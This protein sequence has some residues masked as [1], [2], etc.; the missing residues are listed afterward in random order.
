MS[1]DIAL[2]APS[3][4][5]AP[6]MPSAPS[7]PRQPGPAAADP[8]EIVIVDGPAGG[9][10]ALIR[11]SARPLVSTSM[12]F[13]AGSRDDPAGRSGLAH[14]LEHMMFCGT[15]RFGRSGHL[16]AIQALGGF[17]NA[18]TSADWT[19]HFHVVSPDLLGVLLD[20][21]M[22]RLADAP[23]VMSAAALDIERDVVLNERNQRME[24]VPYGTA[25]ET[26]LSRLYPPGSPYQ[27]LPIGR[28]ED[29]RR[30]GL[31]DC[32]RFHA[33]NYLAPRVN[34]AIVGDFDPDDVTGPVADLLAVLGPG[35]PAVHQPTLSEPPPTDR[36]V[37]R[38][39]FRPKIYLGY[40]LPPAD[41]WDF[42]LARFAGLFLGR[43]VSARL[44]DRLVRQG[45]VASAVTVKTMA[46]AADRSVGIIELV[47]ADGVAPADA[48]NAL[49]RVLA[50]ALDDGLAAADLDRAKAVYRSSWLADDDTFVGRS[51][52]LSLAM[53][54]T[55]SAEMYLRHDARI[56]A[57]RLDELRQ[58]LQHWH[59]PER[60]VELIYAR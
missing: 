18:K 12:R 36:V 4:L 15:R 39:S 8:G 20:L 45:Q 31:D 29:V 21:E 7:A 46:R 27:R 24:S 3:A 10:A 2:A 1:E 43:G 16:K 38:C 26:L 56:S 23:G 58:A 19:K 52:S 33:D 35:A 14:M 55:G 44:P 11:D 6:S 60:R 59:Q 40:L 22:E 47:P 54:L 49:D 30:I 34:L 57:V 13:A 28:I 48:I 9:K 51:D 41:S 5:S 50:E 42:E 32:L 53:Q 37:L 17:A 25:T